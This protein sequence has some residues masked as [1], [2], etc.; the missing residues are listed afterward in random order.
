MNDVHTSLLFS[1]LVILFTF[2]SFVFSCPTINC[3][4]ILSAL[5]YP[6]KR[7][8]VSC[9]G[10]RQSVSLKDQI[11][12]LIH[13]EEQYT[14]GAKAMQNKQVTLAIQVLQD[15]ID[16]FFKI[17]VLPHRSTNMAQEALISCYATL[18]VDFK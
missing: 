2:S 17:A 16:S 5:T 8:Q 7:H 12:E 14:E 1:F 4:S 13:I 6:L 18:Q 15:A 10:C 9:S 3:T 11:E